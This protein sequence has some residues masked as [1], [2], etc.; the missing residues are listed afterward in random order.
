MAVI[1]MRGRSL[2]TD[3]AQT[4]LGTDHRIALGFGESVAA[5]EMVLSPLHRL[6]RLAQGPETVRGAA[7]AG[8]LVVGLDLSAGTAVLVAFGRPHPRPDVLPPG[9]LTGLVIPG[10][11]LAAIRLK[12]V[13][14]R[15]VPGERCP[16]PVLLAPRATLH[17]SF[18]SQPRPPGDLHFEGKIYSPP[19]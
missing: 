8:P 16:R 13:T 11:T 10:R 4:P 17:P 15:L 9:Q 6:A 1:H 7:V 19:F 18:A 5:L 14:H 2:Q 3:H 12:P